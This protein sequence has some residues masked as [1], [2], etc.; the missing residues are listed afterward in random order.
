MFVAHWCPHCNAEVPAIVQ[1]LNANGLPQG[2]DL[3]GVATGTNQQAANF[4]PSDWLH[5]KG[6]PIQT[7]A[8]DQSDTAANAYGVS[9]Y[10]TF[11][12]L[13]GQGKVLARTSGELSMD[14][15]HQL[16]AQ[17]RASAAALGTSADPGTTVGP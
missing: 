11:V 12:V 6:W 14:Q 7:I 2:V 16:I 17:A 3:F 5:D 13:D 9:G 8:D 15:F 10:P 4:P 1:D